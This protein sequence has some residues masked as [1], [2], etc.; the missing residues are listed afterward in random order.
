M[1]KFK[2]S[3]IFLRGVLLNWIPDSLSVELGFRTPIIS[4]MRIVFRIPEAQDS[5]FH[6]KIFPDAGVRIPLQGAVTNDRVISTLE[7]ANTQTMSV[8]RA[9][10]L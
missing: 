9:T 7:Q 8:K 3:G 1:P 4:G 5:R 6:K 2:K 10:P